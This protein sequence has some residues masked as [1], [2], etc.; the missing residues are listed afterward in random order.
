M[1]GNAIAAFIGHKIDASDGEG[2]TLGAVAGIAAW[3]VVRN[4]VPAL[5]VFG[6]IAYGVHRFA[7]SETPA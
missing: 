7:N 6:A 3:K 2:G 5:L 1:I 4:V